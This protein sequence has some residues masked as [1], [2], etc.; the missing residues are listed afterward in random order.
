ME[1]VSSANNPGLES[2]PGFQAK[3]LCGS[4]SHEQ[5]GHKRN[6]R[7]EQQQVN[8][9]AGYVEHQEAASPQNEQQQSNHEEGSE[10][11]FNRLLGVGQ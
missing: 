6:D 4:W 2:W 3:T 5:V 9:A 8:Q 7:E 1:P 11:H 10:P